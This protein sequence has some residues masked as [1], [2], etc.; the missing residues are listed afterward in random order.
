VKEKVDDA[1]TE[2]RDDQGHPVQWQPVGTCEHEF[3]EGGDVGGDEGQQ[4][5]AQQEGQQDWA[6]Q[7]GQQGW[8]Q[9]EG[10]Q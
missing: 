2:T 7:E 4:G 8:A 9:Q 5:W 3:C 10:Q 6:R 1:V